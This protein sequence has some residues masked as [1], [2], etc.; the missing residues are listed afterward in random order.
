MRVR[1]LLLLSAALVTI[2]IVLVI[3]ILLTLDLND[4]RDLVEA[5]ATAVLNRTVAIEGEMGFDVSLPLGIV[6]ED[7]H[8]A[9][10]DWAAQ[11]D[12]LHAG[13]LKAQL[14]L[15]P[16][17]RG[18]VVTPSIEVEDVNVA[19]QEGPD[20]RNT[21]EFGQVS[22]SAPAT[23]TEVS[24][25]L[26]GIP[27]FPLISIRRSAISYQ[28]GDS[29]P[30]LVVVGR[31][32]ARASKNTPLQLSIDGAFRDAPFKF[33]FA[34]GT[35]AELGSPTQ[36][37]PIQASLGLNQ[38]TL[39]A[40]GQ[41]NKPIH[42][43]SFDVQVALT[44]DRPK[45]L[46]A[47]F[48]VKFP[49]IG[50]YELKG[51]LSG[52]RNV[53]HLQDLWVKVGE[54]QVAG[55]LDLSIAGPKKRLVGRLTAETIQL[56]DFLGNGDAARGAEPAP[57]IEDFM[58][59]I[60][61][62]K[63]VDA[64]LSLQFRQILD[65]NH[66]LGWANLTARLED[67]LL[68]VEPFQAG[69]FGKTMEGSLKLNARDEVPSLSLAVAAH[70]FDYGRMLQTLDV[71]DRVEGAIDLAVNFSTRGFSF[72]TLL[73]NSALRIVT[74]QSRLVLHDE[75]TSET[76]S[77]LIIKGHAEV[78]KGRPVKVGVKGTFRQ[79][80]LILD[81]TGGTLADLVS[82]RKPWPVHMRA[83]AGGASVE[84]KGTLL[85]PLTRGNFDVAISVEGERLDSLDPSLPALGPYEL[86]GK[87]GRRGD[88][89]TMSGLK[90][91]LG[92][93]DFAGWSQLVMGDQRPRM[94]T[95]L[96]SQLISSEG[97]A[98]TAVAV[99]ENGAPSN[100]A[101][102][103]LP[104]DQLRS[105]DLGLAWQIERV[106]LGPTEWTDLTLEATLRNGRLQVVPFKGNLWEAA[107]DA[108][109]EVN[110]AG[111]V[112]RVVARL[113]AE[114]LDYGRFAR[115]LEYSKLWRGTAD[116]TLELVGRGETL[117]ELLEHGSLKGNF[118]S[119]SLVAF[120]NEDDDSSG[121]LVHEVRYA[122]HEGGPFKLA[123]AGSY[124]GVPVA[125]T[126]TGG[127]LVRLL[128]SSVRW[129]IATKV[130]AVDATLEL[131]GNV[132]LP[133]DVDDLELRFVLRGQRLDRL[134]QLFN[135]HLPPRGP[136]EFVGLVRD[137]KDG[138]S[139]TGLKG[140]LGDSDVAG[141]LKLALDGP[142]PRLVAHLTSEMIRIERHPKKDSDPSQ[143][144]DV[145]VF[146]HSA[147]PRTDLSSGTA[148]PMT[149]QAEEDKTTDEDT[150][151]ILP[152]GLASG[153]SEAPRV[154]PEFTFP[155]DRLRSLDVDL[156]WEAKSVRGVAGDAIDLG[157]LALNVKLEE[158]KL[159][160][161]PVTGHRP[162]GGKLAASLELD[163][164]QEVPLLSIQG[165]ARNLDYG[166]LLK[167]YAVTDLVEG[168]ADLAVELSGRGNTL[169]E[170]LGQ[171]NG[172]AAFLGGQGRIDNEY[173]DLW[174]GN[175]VTSLLS[176]EFHRDRAT[177][178]NCIVG[179]FD[180][181][182]GVVR[183]DAVLL[184]TTRA[185]V[186]GAGTL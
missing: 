177:S 160:I 96:R 124:N 181:D 53:V 36:A 91:R 99:S 61:P 65:G 133:F 158:G 118:R 122:V 126:E 93:S 104:V 67:G 119:G 151:E 57:S 84:S 114:S 27:D 54:N 147:T 102:L 175:L 159:A 66:N 56:R 98:S 134:N 44:G 25:L 40:S 117:Q 49:E 28:R 15:L 185:T 142:R 43:G 111:S 88:T 146:A 164:S 17:L 103:S 69:L 123:L 11:P 39:T 137:I 87:L 166:L 7:V 135:V 80:P 19:L 47:L 172:G 22:R 30:F 112:P 170:A 150:E 106:V 92:D 168:V 131:Y 2:A 179:Y 140:K 50:P 41:L 32:A 55:N 46:S 178:V 10:P 42:A 75:A 121:L 171:A 165:K 174:A 83:D 51:R 35:L 113:R 132:T 48:D 58:L 129:P 86:F 101:G 180:T 45:T 108:S 145:A 59:P 34:G 125:W 139:V 161:G 52:T 100:P 163:A 1:K 141:S 148:T 33:K 3:G 71:T 120:P 5:K 130:R 127:R 21:W 76:L 144:Q 167:A 79:Q 82:G 13:R 105:V 20:G 155:V 152:F 182:D 62:V 156:H 85:A 70:G 128:D 115:E 97:I 173:F 109:L 8:I 138:L 184:D 4:Y 183:T 95:R 64:D 37:W 153:G 38:T 157:D 23:R 154:F 143:R 77:P 24:A 14:A 90:G 60:G 136:Y 6:L 149:R 74:G 16:L 68:D 63:A 9:N 89:Y 169:R 31:A 29:A 78:R 72:K 110:A 186:A 116:T 94:T 81:F 26:A 107:F 73:G 18:H 162:G 176:P 12:F